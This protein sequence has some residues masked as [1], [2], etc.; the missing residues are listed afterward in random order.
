M[1]SNYI[2]YKIK[3]YTIFLSGIPVYIKTENVKIK[4]KQREVYA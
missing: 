3:K 2:K 1:Y 4:K